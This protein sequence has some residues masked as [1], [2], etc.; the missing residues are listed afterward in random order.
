MFDP[1]YTPA[2]PNREALL[3]EEYYHSR[4]TKKAKKLPPQ[5]VDPL[6]MARIWMKLSGVRII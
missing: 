1:Y 3:R 4:T 2:E 5:K 6:Y